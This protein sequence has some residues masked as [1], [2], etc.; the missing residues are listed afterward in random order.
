MA[1][2]LLPNDD[3]NN[4]FIHIKNHTVQINMRFLSMGYS[5]VLLDTSIKENVKEWKRTATVIRNLLRYEN[6][7]VQDTVK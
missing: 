4:V 7:I 6:K 1:Q 2:Q 3:D 5:P